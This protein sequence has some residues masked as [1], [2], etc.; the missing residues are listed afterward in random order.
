MR[1]K[2]IA[3]N[4]AESPNPYAATSRMGVA[5]DSISFQGTI[6]D[7]HY[8]TL[9]PKQEIQ[10]FAG[11]A[12]CLLAIVL[13]V[14]ITV[15]VVS[16]FTGERN[17]IVGSL[18]MGFLSSFALTFCIRMASTRTRA[19]SYLE[20]FPDLLGAVKGTFQANGL[21]LDDHEKTHWFPWVQLSR[22]VVLHAGVRVPLGD[23][24]RRFLALDDELFDGYRHDE[25]KQ[26]LARNKISKSTYE[27][28]AIASAQ[29]FGQEVGSPSYYRGWTIHPTKWS[30]WVTMLLS[31]VSVVL[32]ILYRAVRGEWNG[33]WIVLLVTAVIATLCS[34]GPLVQMIRNRGQ[35]AVMCWGWLSPTE[36]IHG[37]GVHVMRI[38]MGVMKTIGLDTQQM[39]FVLASGTSLYVY[40][41]LFEDPSHFDTVGTSFRGE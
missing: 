1:D 31:P 22:M 14:L 9:M 29:V 38:P 25:M 11:L 19:K 6:T 21:V 17:G 4:K 33:L 5:P 7:E 20:K 12:I 34:M 40:R 41:N 2:E 30:T 32:F 15:F 27:D 8:R 23:D 10:L 35:T 39:Q 3:E 24:P 26:L 18:V 13:P 16:V 28:L 37:S 36:L